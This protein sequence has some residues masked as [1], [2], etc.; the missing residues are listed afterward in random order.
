MAPVSL[1]KRTQDVGIAAREH[2]PR[3]R[4]LH[5]TSTSSMHV[6]PAHL[7]HPYL[8][9]DMCTSQL[10]HALPRT[11]RQAASAPTD[12][13]LLYSLPPAA[14]VLSPFILLSASSFPIHSPATSLQCLHQQR[15][16]DIY[17][18]HLCPTYY[19]TSTAPPIVPINLAATHASTCWWSRGSL[20]R[21]GYKSHVE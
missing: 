9:P 6:T 5:G 2:V 19:N 10:A 13:Q 20:S 17:T 12:K 3:T 7:L 15:Q 1:L 4:S 21:C 14:T 11:S 18:A 8:R 16:Q